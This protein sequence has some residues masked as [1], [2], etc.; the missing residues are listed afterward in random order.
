MIIR[1]ALSSLTAF[2]AAFCLGLMAANLAYASSFSVHRVSVKCDGKGECDSLRG[3]LEL[4]KRDYSDIEHLKRTVR[5][6][7]LNDGIYSFEYKLRREAKGHV[8]DIN[9]GVKRILSDYTVTFAGSAGVDMPTV[10]PLREGDYVDAG[11]LEKTKGLLV[12]VFQGQ[13]YPD[14]S[15]TIDEFEK[16]DGVELEITVALGEPVLVKEIRVHSDSPFLAE[17]AKKTL[18]RHRKKNFYLL[19]VKNDIEELRQ[20]FIDYGYYLNDIGMSY[21][22]VPGEDVVIDVSVKSNELH[23]FSPEGNLAV[24]TEKIKTAL[25][26]A[27]LSYKRKIPED[28]ARQVVKSLYAERGYINAEVAANLSTYK[29]KDGESVNHYNISA[30]ENERTKIERVRFN[31]N[32]GV[33][34]KRLRSVFYESA[35]DVVKNGYFQSKYVE[36]FVEIIR[37][38]FITRGYVNVMVQEPRTHFVDDRA[39]LTY[40]IREGVKAVISGI[41]IEGVSPE[42]ENDFLNIISNKKDGSFNPVTFKTDLEMIENRLRQEGFYFGKIKNK[43]S[44]NIVAYKNDN[45]NVDINLEIELGERLY[46]DQIIIIGNRKTKSKL[47]RRELILS[48]GDLVTREKVQESQTNLLGLGIFSSVLIEPVPNEGGASDILVSVREKDFGMIELAPGVR[49][50]IGLK[51]SANITYNNLDGMN[52]RISFKGQVNQRFNLNSLDERRR[53]ESSSLMEYDLAANYGE[54]HIFASD[55]DFSASLSSSRRR[56]F[57]FDADIQRIN[58]TFNR[59]FA[60]WL[61]ASLRPQFENIEQFDATS[62]LDEGTF[63]IGS[64]TPSVTFDFRNNRTN[65]TSGAWF[66][67]SVEMANPALLSQK[68]DELTINYYKFISRNRIYLPFSGGTLAMSLAGGIEENLAD[69]G[70][71]YIPN[72]KVFRLNGADIVRGFEDAEINRLPSGEDISEVRVD[73]RAYMAVMKIEPRIFLSDTTML[74]VFYDAGR[75]FVNSFD[76]DNLRSSVGITFKYLTPVGSL[77]FDYGI[78]LLRKT[79][80]DG[81]VD[82]PGRLHVSIGFF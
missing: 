59:K 70:D 72:I 21:D 48:K 54:N 55:I 14:A 80:D 45:S 60:P 17:I 31:G 6:Y 76:S 65:P 57:S 13:G 78:K 23:F 3:A 43:N 18:S 12:E 41:D 11:K 39:Y 4:L 64:L 50:D 66:N 1:R 5:L 42:L 49:T 77:D 20:L 25:K 53:E 9:L 30:V 67:M 16:T 74:G 37:E 81:M 61:S 28:T 15:V 63:Q 35:P 73:D 8:L 47:I 82:S 32:T 19:Q 34:G 24:G 26:N 56:F 27:A 44:K 10:L 51:I 71:G 46:T 69:Q 38:E 68:E 62:E 33:S 36:D 79:Y 58:F 75:V 52:K 29:N 22:L 2:F 7:V 40:R